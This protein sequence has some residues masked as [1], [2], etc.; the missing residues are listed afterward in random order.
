V[1]ADAEALVSLGDALLGEDGELFGTWLAARSRVS[2]DWLAAS[3]CAQHVVLGA[4][5]D[6][7]VWRTELDIQTFEVDHP[8]TQ[9]WKRERVTALQI[10]GG[11]TWV[12]L[13]FERERLGPALS[14][15]GVDEGRGVFVSWHGVI[16]YLTATAVL[17]TLRELPRCLL[18]ISYL[19]PEAAWDDNARRMGRAMVEAVAALGEPWINYTTTAELAE[20]VAEAGFEVVEDVG[21]ADIEGRYGVPAANFE[22][23]ALLRRH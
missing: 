3:R 19:P 2:E 5:L 6:S 15:A 12:P 21:A 17:E 4:G 18:A 23:I 13:D 8:G 7:S 1:G 10:P 11:P 20:L 14:A 16:G 22:R 9:R